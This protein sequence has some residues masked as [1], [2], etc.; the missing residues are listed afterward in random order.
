MPLARLAL[1]GESAAVGAPGLNLI[2]LLQQRSSRVVLLLSAID[3]P[4]LEGDVDICRTQP[5]GTFPC[6][7]G[8]GATIQGHVDE[9]LT[10]QAFHMVWVKPQRLLQVLEG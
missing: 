10:E 5:P 4:E 1:P 8:L 3:G 9:P 7:D 6:G 2:D